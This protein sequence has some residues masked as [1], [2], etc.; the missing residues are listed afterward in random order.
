MSAQ[1]NFQ[2][3]PVREEAG[4]ALSESNKR[5]ANIKVLAGVL[6]PI[7]LLGIVIATSG[8]LGLT[9][10]FATE[11]TAIER[12]TSQQDTIVLDVR[13]VGPID[14]TIQTIFVNEAIWGFQADPIP[15]LARLAPA[16]ITLPYQWV[17]GEPYTVSI[18]TG[19]SNL[20]STKTVD[21][22]FLTPPPT[23]ATVLDLA[24]IGIIV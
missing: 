17:E 10:Q 18:L 23:L 21:L 19:P 11:E 3:L 4:Q 16:K 24:R 22:A 9:G 1:T 6:L 8:S 2:P 14:P 7:I 12:M 13:N 15:Q 5:T 20:G